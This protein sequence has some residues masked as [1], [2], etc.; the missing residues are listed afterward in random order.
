MPVS[1]AQQTDAELGGPSSILVR[2][3]RDHVELDRLLTAIDA[4]SGRKRQDLLTDLCR[5]VF[6]HAFAEESVLWPAIRATLPDGEVLTRTIE[7]EH[8]EINEVFTELEKTDPDSAEHRRLWER[9]KALLKE[10]VRD[11]EDALLPRL[12]EAVPPSRLVSL[13]RTWELVRRTAPTRPHPVVARRP[14]GNALAALPLTLLDRARDNLD[15][16]SRRSSGVASTASVRIS[17]G[18]GRAAGAVEHVPPFTRGEHPSTNSP[19]TDAQ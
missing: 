8:Q 19:R 10:D 11:E 13:G 3:K 1:L 2:Q 17:Q 14:P 7:Q 12:Q 6:P 9:I 5:L 16:F 18:L 15:R 4:A